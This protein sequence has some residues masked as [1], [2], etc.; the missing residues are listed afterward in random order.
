[1]FF[2]LK[3]DLQPLDLLDDDL[4]LEVTPNLFSDSISTISTEKRC[5][6]RFRKSIIQR[7]KAPQHEFL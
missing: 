6:S 4:F 7:Y 5:E 1:M 3:N 2:V